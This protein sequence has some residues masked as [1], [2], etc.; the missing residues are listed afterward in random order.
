MVKTTLLG[1]QKCISLVEDFLNAFVYCTKQPQAPSLSDLNNFLADHFQI[2]SN[3]II[4]A[5]NIN[6]YL[7]VVDGFRKKCF[8][9]TF[10]GLEGDPLFS[11]DRLAIQY[12]PTFND[13]NG[14]ITQCHIMA[15]V[16]F[17]DEK[18]ALWEEVVCEQ[19]LVP[20]DRELMPTEEL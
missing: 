9:V 8:N 14:N 6:E 5:K 12:N 11:D 3:G 16:T 20:W 15:I 10:P 2:K 17:K 1:K 18:I 13:K 7:S 19:G 4:K